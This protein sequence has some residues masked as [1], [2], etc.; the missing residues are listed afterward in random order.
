VLAVPAWKG[1]EGGVVVFMRRIFDP[2]HGVVLNGNDI[3][4]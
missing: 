3:D 4:N 2:V 1:Q